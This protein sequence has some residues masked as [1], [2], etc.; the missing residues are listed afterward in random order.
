MV[1]LV[2]NYEMTLVKETEIRTLNIRQYM[3]NKFFLSCFLSIFNSCFLLAQTNAYQV[4]QALQYVDYK[5]DATQKQLL[6]VDGKADGELHGSS[7]AD[8]N[9]LL[10]Y[11]ATTK[12]DELQKNIE[13]DSVF[14]NNQ[15]ITYIRGLTEMLE[16]FMSSYRVRQIKLIQ[17]PDVLKTWEECFLLDKMQQ[18]IADI[19]FQHPSAVGY[20]AVKGISF[21][22][23]AGLQTAK[24]NLVLKMLQERPDRLMQTLSNYPDLPFADS[25]LSVAVKTKPEELYSYA[26]ATNTKLGRRIKHSSNPEI[27]QICLLANDNNGRLYFPFLDNL[28]KEKMVI[29]DIK[30]VMYNPDEYYKL[31]VKTEIE[32]AARAK[33]GDT[34]VV[35]EALLGML[36]K[37]A[38]ETYVTT[39]NGLHQSPDAVR[40]KSIE[41]LSPQE[42]YYVAVMG[43]IDI[44]TSSYLGVYKRIWPNTPKQSA[45]TLLA[46]VANDRYKKFIT[47]AANYNTLDDF[48]GKMS[49]ENAT[50]LMV[51]FVN[52]LDKGKGE[53][54]IEDAVDVANA[55]ASIKKP[56]LKNLMLEH[57][58]SSYERANLV[59]N[60]K[61]KTIYNIEKLIMESADSSN[62]ID[63]SESL[64][65]LP[66]YGVKNSYLRDTLGRIVMQM[67]FFG[68]K[69][70]MGNFASYT[71]R[72][73]N[74]NWKLI[75]TPWWYQFTSIGTKVP[76]VLFA[77]RAL[78][79][80]QGL[81]EIA[82][83]SLNNWMEMHNYEP[84]IT[85]HRGHSYFLSSTIK[86]LNP[87][88]K[89]AILGSC[90][91]YHN[92]SDIL[93][94]C[95]DASIIG[96]KQTGFG[97]INNALIQYTIDQLAKG[98]DLRWPAM[99]EA[100]DKSVQANTKE[101][102]KLDG[103]EDY[104]FPHQNLGAIFIKAY[105]K[106][107]DLNDSAL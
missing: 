70:G 103:Y 19:M 71:S 102:D 92:L 78:D 17:F 54:D 72:F 32:Y 97:T 75:K 50:A 96:S 56:E 63:L 1:K 76:F 81:D 52:N 74:K 105:K 37:K 68:D 87:S 30:K 26:Q 3:S 51:D 65:I 39:I 44:Y 38:I 95:P 22:E 10:T 89:V 77:N 107:E 11:A 88:T 73:D 91:A 67:Y 57:I 23:N 99:K 82:Q 43:E 12:V 24:N 60:K 86:K 84:A 66:V 85:V 42:L 41:K 21:A 83:D 59:G 9:L 18:S 100:V 7:N 33:T 64:G 101:K 2:D 5:L 36:Q 20:I 98:N 104:I 45:D 93:N 80:N 31:L 47:L 94:T 55:Y 29:A 106:A 40:F 34:A 4:P 48:L 79:E 53:N 13:L 16:N 27:K 15:K 49:K 46:M 28:L 6:A 14:N 8:I 25:L 58:S 62:H 35:W 90:G 69:D 61:G